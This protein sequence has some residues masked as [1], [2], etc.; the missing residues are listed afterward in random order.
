MRLPKC[1]HD[2]RGSATLEL[3]LVAPV[4]LLLV[5]GLLQF[6]L[7]YHAQQVAL[8]SA[9]EGARVA[10]AES[11]A[12]VAG[13]ARTQVLLQAG[14]GSEGRSASVSASAGRAAVMVEV[15]GSIPML[16]PWPGGLSLPI[17]ARAVAYR[18]RFVPAQG[19]P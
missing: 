11:G 7:W 12:L 6:G 15:H 19:S 9:Q 18:E 13:E 8:A 10:A 14:L 4:L 2:E 17:H 1:L 5:V 3:A 16:F